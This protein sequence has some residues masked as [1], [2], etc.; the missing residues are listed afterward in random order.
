MYVCTRSI[1]PFLI[2]L[3]Y[4]PVLRVYIPT[5]ALCLAASAADRADNPAATVTAHVDVA[6]ARR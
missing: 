1:F 3:I 6:A 4:Q 5:S 2:Q